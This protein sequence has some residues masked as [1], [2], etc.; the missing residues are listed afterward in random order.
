[1]NEHIEYVIT[2]SATSCRHHLA[3]MGFR[4]LVVNIN[5]AT[6]R[7]RLG[8]GRDIGSCVLAYGMYSSRRYIDLNIDGILMQ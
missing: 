8:M 3:I 6:M 5:T 1:M 2:S 4:G 7:C